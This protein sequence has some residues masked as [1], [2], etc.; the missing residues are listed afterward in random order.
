VGCS[1]LLNGTTQQIAVSVRS[2]D[3]TPVTGAQCTLVNDRGS[4]PVTAPNATTV[5]RS[6]HDLI[7]TCTANDRR[8]GALVVKSSLTRVFYGSQLQGLDFA[9]G[10]AYAYPELVVVALHADAGAASV[11][12]T[13][14]G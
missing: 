8:T 10:A 1:T 5:H 14:P 3:G 13:A 6:L 11:S 12:T 7:V 2:E 9:T 4:W